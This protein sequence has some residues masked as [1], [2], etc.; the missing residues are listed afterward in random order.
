MVALFVTGEWTFAMIGERYHITSAYA[1]EVINRKSG[2]YH[3]PAYKRVCLWCGVAFE[4]H[5]SHQIYC[6]SGHAAQASGKR[7][8]QAAKAKREN[9]ERSPRLTIALRYA[10]W[11]RDDYNA[12]GE[13]D[14]GMWRL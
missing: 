4:A 5:Y 13:W 12:F 11:R 9:A 14:D 8:R 7:L 2:E 10:R 1:Q 3:A 6:S